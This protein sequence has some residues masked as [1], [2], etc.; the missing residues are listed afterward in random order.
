MPIR[1]ERLG[2]TSKARRE[3]RRNEFVQK[4]GV[5]DKVK[6]FAEID[7]GEDCSRAQPGFVKPIQNGLRKTQNLM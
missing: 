6:S 4:G 3:V 5:P 7:N 1:K 2:P